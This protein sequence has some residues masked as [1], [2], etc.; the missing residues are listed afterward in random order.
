MAAFDDI[1]TQ[2]GFFEL[3]N[4]VIGGRKEPLLRSGPPK[5]PSR[6]PMTLETD[7]LDFIRDA[8]A[9]M[10]HVDSHLRDLGAVSADGSW[11][12]VDGSQEGESFGQY[13]PQDPNTFPTTFY[14][15]FLDTKVCR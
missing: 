6:L 3:E 10:D 4:T 8:K 5:I 7:T 11:A 15:V 1:S 13:G 12:I 9:R 2:Q 14:E